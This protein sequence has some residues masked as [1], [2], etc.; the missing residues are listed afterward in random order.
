MQKKQ[1]VISFILVLSLLLSSLV[2]TVGA[3]VATDITDG[4]EDVEFFDPTATYE[5]AT[6][7]NVVNTIKKVLK[8]SVFNHQQNITGAAGTL[9]TYL[10]Q[11]KDGNEYLMILPT[12]EAVSAGKVSVQ[13]YFDTRLGTK[14]SYDASV[15]Q[16][17]I[18]DFDAATES[19]NY[20]PMLVFPVTRNSKS[21]GQWTTNYDPSAKFGSLM[22]PGKFHH[23][24]LICE[25]N[26]N[27]FYVFVDNV[28][29]DKVNNGVT[30]PGF[31]TDS[32]I[33]NKDTMTISGMRF[34]NPNAGKI[35]AG[36]SFCVDN[37]NERILKGND[38]IGNIA[39]CIASGSLQDWNKNIY[40]PE[41]SVYLPDLIEIN[42][43]KYN[44][45]Y[46]AIHMLDTYRLG[47]RA[48]VLRSCYSESIT[49][50]C[51][52]IIST[53]I[54]E[55]EFTAG[56]DVILTKGEGSTWVAKLKPS[57]FKHSAYILPGSVNQQFVTSSVRYPASDNLINVV[58]QNNAVN[59][60]RFSLED[61]EKMTDAQRAC[62]TSGIKEMPAE[63]YN[64]LTSY[65]RQNISAVTTVEDGVEVTKYLYYEL[66]ADEINA[67]GFDLSAFTSC[68]VSG[69]ITKTDNGNEYLIIRD[70]TNETG[71]FPLNV[72]YQVNANTALNF[73]NGNSSQY[74][75][76]GHDFLVFEQDIYSESSFI[77]VYNGFNLRTPGNTALSAMAVF[78]ENVSITPEKWYHLTYIG[79][80]ATGNSFLFLDGQCIAMI[81]GGLYDDTAISRM[82]ANMGIENNA[83]NRSTLVNNMLVA[84]FRTMQ[85]AG[86]NQ[87]GKLLHPDMSAAS[88][89][90]YLRWADSDSS[91]EALIDA[92]KA[93]YNNVPDGNDKPDK[94]IDGN[95]YLSVWT[96]N[97]F[98]ENYPLPERAAIAT[99]NG[100]EYFDTTSINDMLDDLDNP[101]ESGDF[102]EY[103]TPVQ[104]IVLY[105]E[106]IGTINIGCR[107]TVKLNGITSHVAYADGLIKVDGD[108]INVYKHTDSDK[109]GTYYPVACVNG[110][111]YYS[112]A[113]NIDSNG[114]GKVDNES[115][116]KR[117]LEEDTSS[118]EFNV[119]FLRVPT[120]NIH[121]KANAVL[122]FNGLDTGVTVNTSEC[123][124]VES[125]TTSKVVNLKTTMYV[126]TMNGVDYKNDADGIAAL[127]AAI[128]AAESVVIELYNV[129]SQPL[130][131][132]CSANIDTN[133][134][135]SGSVEID[136]LITTDFTSFNITESDGSY[137]YTVVDSTV[138]FAT[139]RIDI[140]LLAGG[141]VTKTVN[142]RV[143]D[144]IED[145]LKAE[146][147]MSGV[148]LTKDANGTTVHA[149]E[150]DT[151]PEGTILKENSGSSP[152]YTF[153]AHETASKLLEANYAYVKDGVI[154]DDTQFA[155]QDVISWFGT[156]DTRAIIF[157]SDLEMS[158]T[159]PLYGTKHIYLNGHTINNKCTD[160]GFRAERSTKEI[161]FYGSG[162]IKYS[163]T[164]INKA[165]F[166][167][168]Y[169]LTG[170]VSFN[171]LKIETSAAVGILREGHLVLNGCTVD[172]Y[173]VGAI[174]LF[175]IGE[176]FNGYSQNDISILIKNSDISY[177]YPN[178]VD[179]YTAF[180]ASKPLI[181]SKIVTH[182]VVQENNVYVTAGEVNDVNKTIVI[183][184]STVKSQG[185]LVQANRN[186]S[187]NT[188]DY[189]KSALTLYINNSNILARDFSDGVIKP[190]TII[191]YDDVRTNIEAIDDVSISSN[192]V[193]AKTSDGIYKLLYTSHDYAVITWSNGNKEYW[194]TGST[195]TNNSL[196]FDNVTANGVT[197]GSVYDKYVSGGNKFAFGLI[198]SL[199]L[200]DRI[201]FNL[202]V[203]AEINGQAVDHRDVTVY[204]DG[205]LLTA[206]TYANSSNVRKTV[207][208]AA[209]GKNYGAGYCYD[210]TLFLNPQDAAK[211]F[212]IVII[213][214]GKS[215]SRKVSVAD[216]AEALVNKGLSEKNKALLQTTLA[217]I[218]QA[219]MYAGYN[220]DMSRI[221]ALRSKLGTLSVSPAAPT[222]PA[223]EHEGV[224]GDLRE[225]IS[226]VQINV[227]SSSAIRFNLTDPEHADK[228][229]FY[230]ANDT[231]DGY[232]QRAHTVSDDG[233]YVELSL[234]GY[235]MARS[236]KIVYTDGGNTKYRLYS[237]Y[238]YYT[239]LHGIAHPEEQN[240]GK[241]VGS[242]HESRAAEM[243]I[244]VLYTYASICDKY[245]D[246]N[247]AEYDPS[248][249]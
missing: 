106:Y 168:N 39:D 188:N 4:F 202:Y 46:D 62:F 2:F 195:P 34:Q 108:T 180:T 69:S 135:V 152:A 37:I 76:E 41:T 237:L 103:T 71:D 42:G 14:I 197:E 113:A 15:P 212:T 47:N 79:E 30:N 147:F 154:Y 215:V 92:I 181:Y 234:R 97:I 72:H 143:G 36:S 52:A 206:N 50:N 115:A 8:T 124:V 211:D 94:T 67:E 137:D 18:T 249:N 82:A 247:A 73:Y 140:R 219:T 231:G 167:S 17:Y 75:L 242:T 100:V 132:S 176:E 28:F 133:G 209:T 149:A 86:E 182:A 78:A 178:A 53:S 183:D 240:G 201:G 74:K 81:E 25:I 24:T 56:S 217:Y 159:A 184:G 144:K 60:R 87:T 123:T 89:N 12:P 163:D 101:S 196:K 80:V 107:A 205:K 7:D 116:L 59:T 165:L 224:A 54:S 93:D 225:Y 210:Y 232:E 173:S 214:G 191:F 31:F 110:V 43:V 49:V 190:D 63:V 112:D 238:E 174:A 38:S 169:S 117:M 48:K 61:Y 166:F 142:A 162:T 114:D 96:S 198:A 243:L 29:V 131:I 58:H 156:T 139:V 245:C 33:T 120:V 161:N 179:S 136:D 208:E 192:L 216:Y 99:I 35:Q 228:L 45:T 55:V 95:H 186:Q 85:I 226:D 16:Y 27:T 170:K 223:V 172:A 187:N 102:A 40:Y 20:L 239:G 32:F 213:Y 134:L 5:V 233:S 146:G 227:K 148:F 218:E 125:F 3:D 83:E 64:K 70:A 6:S 193:K 65:E 130:K 21:E 129:P 57:V 153:T 220:V 105:R 207:V 122:D 51:D 13:S 9:E 246:K 121:V 111:L 44:N 177:R 127:Q 200:S 126:A 157:N 118:T 10:V 141:S 77:N 155:A 19:S 11:P 171:N 26:T 199:T 145:V 90:Y 150:W 164:T 88:D 109:D 236:I 244:E 91:M 98:D 221:S 151:L 23:V 119:T 138:K 185:P 248:L 22:T 203:P 229:T 1:R 194:A 158:A 175:E 222:A 104:E 189:M 128:T 204:L 84:S 241:V 160:H 66:T 230:V 235:E 68:A